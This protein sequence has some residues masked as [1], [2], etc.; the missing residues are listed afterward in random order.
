MERTGEKVA[1]RLLEELENELVE[2][3]GQCNEVKAKIRGIPPQKPD[4]L[5]VFDMCEHQR[6]P[7]VEGGLMDQPHFWLLQCEKII[8]TKK[9]FQF[10]D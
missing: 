9:K 6:L 2:Y 3:F 10:E 8:Q 1:G 4:T 5:S 7:L